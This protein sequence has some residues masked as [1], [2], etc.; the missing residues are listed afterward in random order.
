MRWW[1]L[2]LLWSGCA[3]PEAHSSLD[4][5]EALAARQAC[6]FAAGAPANLTVSRSTAVGDEIPID[7][8]IALVLEGRS[9]DHLLSRLPGAEGAQDRVI[10]LDAGG[11]PSARH[12]MASYCVGES[13]RDWNAHHVAWDDGR[14]D[15]FARAGANDDPMGYYTAGD[16]PGLYGIAGAFAVADR[17]FASALA[18]PSVNRLFLYAGSS[19]GAV[20]EGPLDGAHPT[21][22]SALDDAG[23]SF[24]VYSRVDSGVAVLPDVVA[25][26]RDRFHSQAELADA[27]RSGDLPSVAIVDPLLDAFGPQREDFGASGDVQVGD[28]FLVHFVE[29]VMRSPA[30]PRTALLITFVDEGGFFEH[31]APP[32]ACAPDGWAPRL[33]AGD[34][35]GGFDRLGFRVPLIVVSPWARRGFV[36]HATYDHASLL[37]FLESR[38]HL[39]ALTARDANAD[40][41]SELFDFS[42]PRLDPPALPAVSIDPIRYAACD[43]DDD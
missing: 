14:V 42:A 26:H 6:R 15:G 23:V 32:S 2:V 7:H 34:L 19:F 21:L 30:W 25:R 22:F 39:P 29:A 31:V 10:D 33:G 8:V 43:P 9:F 11:H 16:L 17:Y 27:L 41:L 3:A 35:P 36:G 5:E 4:D 40:P 13:A 1:V 20:G 37:R 24:G 28:D 18:P 12:A 38:F